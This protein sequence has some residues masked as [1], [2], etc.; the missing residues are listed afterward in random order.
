MISIKKHWDRIARFYDIVSFMSEGSKDI[1]RMKKEIFS[2]AVGNVLEVGVGTGANL[3]YYREESNFAAIDVSPEMVKRARKK[4]QMY[5]KKVDFRVMDVENLEFRDST[6]DTVI[7]TCVFCSVP[8]PV[9]GLSEVYRVLKPGGKLMMYE[10]VLSENKILKP[11]MNF[12][13]PFF[14]RLFGPNINR[15]T[16]GN[17]K[18]AGFRIVRDQNIMFGDIFKRIEC[19]K[20]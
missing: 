7:S 8:D 15:D 14:H 11:L 17:L 13:N 4:A 1:I 6:F 16:I 20:G 19:V 12:L 5:G 2:R 10:H 9:K 3:K 18:R